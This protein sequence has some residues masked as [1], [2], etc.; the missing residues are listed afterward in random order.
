MR[1]ILAIAALAALGACQPEAQQNA[2]D[3]TAA[4][5]KAIGNDAAGNGAEGNVQAVVLG[6]SDKVRNGVLVRAIMDSQMPCDGVER[7]ER[8]P[9]QQGAPA[10]KA[11]CRNGSTHIVIF[12]VDGIAKVLSPTG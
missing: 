9:D 11:Y 5:L 8:L 6:M 3:N 4:E 1:K 12:T 7:S 10:W 2:A